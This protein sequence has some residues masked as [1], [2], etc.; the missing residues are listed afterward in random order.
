MHLASDV[1]RPLTTI[2][3]GPGTR[4]ERAAR[5]AE[6]VRRAGGFGWVGLY[7]VTPTTIAAIAWTGVEAPTYPAFPRSQGL[8]GIA[9]STKRPVIANDVAKHPA[10]LTTFAATGA[11]MIVPVLDPS[12]AAV[13]TIDVESPTVGA[14]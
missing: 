11:E 7:D 13:G 2:L 5:A 6:T 8:N 9:V 4:E 3:T 14:F 10:Y 12:G 1:A